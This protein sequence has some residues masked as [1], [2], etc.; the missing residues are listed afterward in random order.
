[1]RRRLDA[2]G[3]RG[4]SLVVTRPEGRFRV[5]LGLDAMDGVAEGAEG[6]A[7]AAGAGASTAGAAHREAGP[8]PETARA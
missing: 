7:G 6:A 3:S 4:A 1:V 5:T 2:L 8:N